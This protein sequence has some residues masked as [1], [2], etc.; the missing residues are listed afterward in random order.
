[1]KSNKVLKCI[2]VISGVV[3]AHSVIKIWS[4]ELKN[5]REK[6][7]FFSIIRRGIKEGIIFEVDGKIYL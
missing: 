7:R 5:I 3:L 6:E 1:M 2:A 4:N